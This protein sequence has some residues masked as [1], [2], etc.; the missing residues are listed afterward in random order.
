MQINIIF[1]KIKS[2]FLSSLTKITQ[3]LIMKALDND[4]KKNS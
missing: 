2:N 1:K 3:R 4:L